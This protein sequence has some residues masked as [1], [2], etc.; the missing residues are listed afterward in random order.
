MCCT[1]SFISVQWD[2]DQAALAANGA[3]CRRNLILFSYGVS[4]VPA[5]AA[6]AI[7][8]AAPVVVVAVVLFRNVD[9]DVGDAVGDAVGDSFVVSVFKWVLLALLVSSSK[10]M[11]DT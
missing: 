5:A 11:E 1:Y 9:D 2:K 8:A 6:L 4:V 3:T 7:V 10:C